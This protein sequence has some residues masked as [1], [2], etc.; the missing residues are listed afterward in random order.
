MDF[1][2]N[3]YAKVQFRNANI[4]FK[5]GLITKDEWLAI[6]LLYPFK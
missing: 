1:D 4:A 6:V 3:Y 2:F 5:E